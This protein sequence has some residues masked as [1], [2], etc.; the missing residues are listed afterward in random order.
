MT[1]GSLPRPPAS[2]CAAALVA[3]APS[4]H[5]PTRA[6]RGC[7]AR[8]PQRLPVLVGDGLCRFRVAAY[9]SAER[10]Q[11]RGRIALVGNDLDDRRATIGDDELRP[12]TLDFTHVLEGPRLE[13][14]FR[15]RT[16][17]HAAT[18]SFVRT[19]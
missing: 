19:R 2:R 17:C 10:L 4:S 9:R 18:P 12:G 15:H 11:E 1:R 5:P 6:E 8:S 7:P 3:K 13:A 16:F 14:G